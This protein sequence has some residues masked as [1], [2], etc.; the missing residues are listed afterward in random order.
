MM[1]N[2]GK[3]IDVTLPA[4]PKGQ[5]WALHVDTSEPDVTP[6]PMR[7]GEFPMAA[8]SVAVFLLEPKG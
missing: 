8:E 4:A 5:I 3:A 6:I 1:F 2:I 7:T